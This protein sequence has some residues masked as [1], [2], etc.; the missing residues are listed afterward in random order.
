VASA[1]GVEPGRSLSVAFLVRHG[2]AEPTGRPDRPLSPAGERR[3]ERLA[4]ILAGEGIA[5]I[6]SSSFPRSRQ[7]AEPLAELLGLPVELYDHQ[8]LEGLAATLIAES[9]RVLV[10][11]HSN[12]TG[13][14][15]SLLGGDSGG[16]IAEEEHDRLYV[17]DL[18]TGATEIRRYGEPGEPAATGNA[19]DRPGDSHAPYFLGW[20]SEPTMDASG[21]MVDS[22]QRGVSRA[23]AA[24]APSRPGL[25]PA[26]EFP[27][28]VFLS[29]VQHEVAG[30]GGRAREFD[31]RPSYGF[32]F[33]FSA[34][35]TIAREPQTNEEVALL[36][37]GGSEANSVLAH[38]ALLALH[39]PDGA[40]GAS[41][42]LALVAK[43][44]LTLYVAGTPS[45]T[46]S[47]AIREEMVLAFEQGNDVAIYLATRQAQ[48]RGADPVSVWQRT[49]EIDFD[50]PRLRQDWRAV[51]RA[52][53]WNALDPALVAAGVAYFRHHVAGGAVR[54]R[55]P[56]LPLGPR[57][58]LGVG[59]RGALG[60]E[61]VSRYL[62]LYL[63]TAGP[64]MRVYVRDLASS[65]ERTWGTG[66][67][68]HELR[69][70]EVWKV[71][72]VADWW[73]EPA[74]P[75]GFYRGRGWHGGA[76]VEAPLAGRWGATIAGGAKSSGFLPGLPVASG[77][78]LGAGLTYAWPAGRRESAPPP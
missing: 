35:T 21:R 66:A 70:G 26:W 29:L 6:L 12:T 40:E 22:A 18:A 56:T 44:D 23:F 17:V 49:F 9:V 42:P 7:T 46:G 61:S 5:R 76:E 78:Y 24:I 74:A 34:Y 50:E 16:P 67:R 27:L 63:V 28:A 65:Q 59:T 19:P 10:V 25:A 37:V 43:L 54:I 15:A 8:D 69:V 53:T 3:A 47:A 31:L 39:G 41:F 1:A 58:R 13:E 30:H 33:D 36:S 51:R 64:L 55:A 73:Q 57:A 62:D 68:L 20:Q 38:R 4:E 11:G 71:S 14:L 48:R 72:L 32:G 52:A 2:E 77:A 45:P 60:P 75:E